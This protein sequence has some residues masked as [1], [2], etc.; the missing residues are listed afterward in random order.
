MNDEFYFVFSRH[1]FYTD[2]ILIK[3][4]CF[5]DYALVLIQ[6]ISVHK[7]IDVVE[8]GIVSRY[9]SL[10]S[11]PIGEVKKSLGK[12]SQNRLMLRHFGI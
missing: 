9:P 1:L 3:T 12:V 11:L 2:E 4:I 5:R 7:T 6:F 8:I 10:P